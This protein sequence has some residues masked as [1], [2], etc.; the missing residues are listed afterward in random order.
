MNDPHLVCGIERI[1]NLA[2]DVERLAALQRKIDIA[3]QVGTAHHP[4]LFGASAELLTFASTPIPSGYHIATASPAGA[5]LVI[6]PERSLGGFLRLSPEG[7]RLAWT[8]LD[9]VRGN[10]DIWYY[11]LVRGT[12]VRVTTFRDHDVLPVWS[13]DGR[14]IAYR[15]GT[16][17]APMLKVSSADGVGS[18]QTLPALDLTASLPFHIRRW[19]RRQGSGRKAFSHGQPPARRFAGPSRSRSDRRSH[20]TADEC[21]EGV[22]GRSD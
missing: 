18:V 10:N 19:H 11:D 5:D 8:L 2:G 12:Q 14:R 7:G 13:P 20:R 9:P 16:S 22:D 4:A 17:A 3:A 15:S 21:P 6:W 1:G